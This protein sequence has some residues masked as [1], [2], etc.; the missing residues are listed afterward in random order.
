MVSV[1]YFAIIPTGT[2]TLVIDKDECQVKWFPVDVLGI[3]TVSAE[4]LQAREAVMQTGPVPAI[5]NAQAA[6]GYWVKPGPGYGPKYQGTVWSV[7]FLAQLGARGS[8]PRVKAGC[9][10]VL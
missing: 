2:A 1:V 8:D 6:G 10:T 7:I 5:L 3:P 9:E 4:A